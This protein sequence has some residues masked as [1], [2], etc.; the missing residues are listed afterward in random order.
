MRGIKRANG[1]SA[2]A[3]SLAGRGHKTR[4]PSLSVGSE[5][6]R[7]DFNPLAQGARQETVATIVKPP[8]SK[9]SW[10]QN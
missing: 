4:S 7:I 6:R 9:F 8:N 2:S 10:K 5:V 3:S 1:E